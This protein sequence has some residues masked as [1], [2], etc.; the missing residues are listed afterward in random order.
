MAIPTR[1]FG[2]TE[3][4]MP[5]LSLGGMRFQQSWSDLPAD[6]ITAESQA[7]LCATLEAA[8]AAGLHH[9]ETARHYGTSERQLG[10]LLVEVPDPARI[11]QTKVPPQADADA[12]EAELATS[13]ERLAVQRVE[14]L[15]IH[16]L[17]LPE[18]L[19]HTLRPG[20]CLDV[21]RRWQAEGRIGHIG[22]STHAPLPLIR[23]AIASDAFDYVNL[24]WYFIRQDTWP[25]IE[26]A[27]EHDMGVFVISPTDKGGHLH[28]PSQ[29]LLELCGPLHPIVFN[30]LFCLSARLDAQLGAAPAVHTL[31]LG[32][33]RPEDLALHLEAVARLDQASE[34]LA[35][36]LQR[37]EAARRQALG[38][39]WL[40]SWSAGLPD[41]QDTPG[42]INLPV[43]LWLHNLL[44]AWDLESFAK[45]RYGLLGNGGHWFPGANAD[46]LDH[47]VSEAQ[48]RAVLTGSPWAERIPGIL[49]QLQARLGGAAVKRLSSA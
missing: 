3:L 16:G 9:I 47:G 19:E 5:V 17:N 24:H 8:V 2:R 15:A 20:G 30:D 42:Q 23:A 12:F 18:H 43:L 27:A 34:L 35:P 49:R 41:W 29:R 21:A 37:L 46:A 10:W 22:F 45:A 26:L 11:L 40:A 39:R 1:R 44:S 31:S 7:N 38:E 28:T 6:Q 14:L 48:L 36:V 33:A 32:A 13:F 4:A 25:A